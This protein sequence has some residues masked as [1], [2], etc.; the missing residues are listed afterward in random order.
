[1][2]DTDIRTPVKTIYG[3]WWEKHTPT[4]TSQIEAAKAALGSAITDVKMPP[5]YP[6][7][8]PIVYADREKIAEVVGH[9][10]SAGYDFLADMTAT[11]EGGEPRFEVVYNL[12][13]MKPHGPRFR[14]KAKVGEKEEIPTIVG[15]W[16]AADWLEREI[17]DMFGIRF[18]GHPNL[19]RILMDYR[20]E[21]FPLRKDYPLDGYQ[22]FPDPEPPDP[23]RLK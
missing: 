5:A 19:R 13:S 22:V 1:M 10:K 23:E 14:I 3:D 9:F 15:L 16:P 4:W 6:T 18:R 11:D 7:D 8:V 21:G 20:W 2:T 17:W 12:Y